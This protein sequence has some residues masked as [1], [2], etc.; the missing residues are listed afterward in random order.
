EKITG[1]RTLLLCLDEFERLEEVVRE[2]GSRIPLNFL[3]HVIQHRSRWTL[4]FSGSHLPEELAPYWSDYLI[5]TRSVR[6]SYLGEADTRDLIRR[7]VEGFPDI[8]DD[9]AVEAIVRLTRGQPYLVQLT[10]HELVERLNREKRQRATAADVEAVVPALFERGY[11]YF[12]EFWKGLTPEQRTVLL[13]VARGKETAD[14]MPPVAEHLVKKEVLER[15]DEA[16]RFQVPLVER[17]VAEKGAGHY[18]PTAR[19]A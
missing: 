6:V 14:E 9:G 11:M 10:C 8:Y 4:L 7:P 5:N 1:D 18:G 16:Y 15:A 19:G 13:A 12:D 3:R 2:T 17:W